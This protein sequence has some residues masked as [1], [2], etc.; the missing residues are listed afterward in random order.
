VTTKKSKKTTSKPRFKTGQRVIYD[1]WL[2]ARGM[3]NIPATIVSLAVEGYCGDGLPEEDPDNA[4]MLSRKNP[5][6]PAWWYHV[7][8]AGDKHSRLVC[9]DELSLPP[10]PKFGIG[11]IVD[12]DSSKATQGLN[13]AIK[14]LGGVIVDFHRNED[15]GYSYDVWC[16]DIGGASLQRFKECCLSMP[17]PKKGTPKP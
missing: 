10:G 16:K 9:E 14:G 6:K 5:K 13:V 15:H 8:L 4:Q 17:K 2:E 12:Y 3:N 7:T 11:N 1:T